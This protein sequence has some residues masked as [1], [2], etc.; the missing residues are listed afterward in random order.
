MSDD[1]VVVTSSS[2]AAICAILRGDSFAAPMDGLGGVEAF[3]LE[4][5]RHGVMPLL[6]ACFRCR[7]EIQVPAAVRQACR[8]D[9]AVSSLQAL[10]TRRELVPVLAALHGAGVRPLLLK[11]A[12]LAHTHYP[13]PA[14]RPRADTDILI[15]EQQVEAAAAVLEQRGYQRTSAVSGALIAHQA[16]WRRREGAAVAHCL[17]VHWRISNAHALAHTLSHAELAERAMPIPALGPHAL[18]LAPVHA[19][20]LACIHRAGHVNAPYHVDGH[21]VGADRLIW[22]YDIHRL[23]LAM[24]ADAQEEFAALAIRRKVRTICHDAVQACVGRFATPVSPATIAALAR[25]GPTEPSARCL[26]RGP[27]R[28]VIGDFIALDGA[29]KRARWMKELAFPAA[30]YMR[31]RY[32][33]VTVGWLPFLYA[34]RGLR[35]V[36][37]WATSRRSDPDA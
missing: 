36:W 18:A 19:L 9:A 22:L 1:D 7:G 12:A 6:D 3:L 17:D 20:L 33:D 11:G 13:T 26:R 16:E 28:Q 8:A 5:R 24:T 25:S 10:A 35:G 14:L 23:L 15:P 30:A 29:T 37:R 27:M 21:A 4:A 34:R 32:P 31:S 2:L